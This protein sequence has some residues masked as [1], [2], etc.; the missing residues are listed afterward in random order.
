M[1]NNIVHG[2]IDFKDKLLIYVPEDI[3]APS[4]RVADDLSFSFA[5][6]RIDDELVVLGLRRGYEP[7][8]AERR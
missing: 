1:L 7:R 6:D 2:C 8:I 5:C 4:R 3:G